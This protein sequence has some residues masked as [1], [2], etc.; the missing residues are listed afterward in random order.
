[1]SFYT[2][3]T[4]GRG[5]SP[6][7]M[8]GVGT[9]PHPVLPDL[10]DPSLSVGSST[11]TIMIVDAGKGGVPPPDFRTGLAGC[12]IFREGGYPPIRRYECVHP[13][14]VSW[15]R[16]GWATRTNQEWNPQTVSKGP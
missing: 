10:P 13:P 15:S 9:P 7:A 16:A 11:Q 4:E 6:R 14:Q 8:G 5:A 12:L 1:M 3:T 2:T